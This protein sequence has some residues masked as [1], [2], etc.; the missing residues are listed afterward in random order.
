MSFLFNWFW[1][2]LKS[3]GLA[4]KTGTVTFLGLDNAGKTTLMHMLKNQH[5]KQP[6]PT[7][8]PTNEEF[9]IENINFKAWDLGGHVQARRLW[10]TYFP[11]VTAIVFIVDASDYERM[12]EAN[13]ELKS[14]LEAED[15]KSIPVA[16]LGNKI[17]KPEAADE[18]TLRHNLG[19]TNL[20]TGKGTVKLKNV[21]PVE[22]FMCSIVNKT[23]YSDAFRWISQYI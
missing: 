9:T 13:A 8:H 15:I 5:L 20:T 16:I 17:D 4:N 14:L 22:I 1:S 7:F 11:V 19:M 12:E 18:D 2:F 3:V 23:G 21:R 6:V 10:K